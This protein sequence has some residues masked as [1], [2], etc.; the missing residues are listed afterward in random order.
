MKNVLRLIMNKIVDIKTYIIQ[1]KQY[2]KH[3]M[4]TD[5]AIEKEEIEQEMLILIW[6]SFINSNGLSRVL[7]EQKP[8]PAWQLHLLFLNAL[9]NLNLI[10]DSDTETFHHPDTAKVVQNEDG[11]IID[12]Y[13]PFTPDPFEEQEKETKKSK[14]PQGKKREQWL[15]RIKRLKEKG[16]SDQEIV[17]MLKQSK[18]GLLF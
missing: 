13:Y 11:E 15:E 5:R 16:Y 6:Q 12:F 18:Q 1:C 3:Y 17:E 4:S 7:K 10:S 9:R 14:L 8:I 2:V